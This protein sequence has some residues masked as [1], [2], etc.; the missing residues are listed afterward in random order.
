M[1]RGG[2]RIV[3]CDYRGHERDRQRDRD[4][5][6]GAEHDNVDS[7]GNG[8]DCRH[9]RDRYAG[10][11]AVFVRRVADVAVVCIERRHELGGGDLDER[12]RL[13]RGDQRVVDLR[14]VGRERIGQR[15]SRLLGRG[16]HIDI[17][18][19]GN[20]N[21]CRYDRDGYAGGGRVLVQ[22][23]AD[24]S[25]RDI[26]RRDEFCHGHDNERLQLD[27]G[28]QRV[29]AQRHHWR[30]RIRQ[31]D[32][33][34]LSGREY[35]DIEPDRNAHDCRYDRDCYAGGGRMRV[36]RVAHVAERRGWRRQRD[37]RCDDDVRVCLDG[38]EQRVLDHDSERRVRNRQW[39]RRARG[40]RELPEQRPNGQ[41]HD[42]RHDGD[43][44]GS[45]AERAGAAE[46]Y[47]FPRR[48]LVTSA[49]KCRRQIPMLRDG[50]DP[51][52]ETHHAANTRGGR[53]R[54]SKPALARDHAR[55]ARE[56]R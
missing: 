38:D 43:R 15:H 53:W 54:Q 41:R 28:E 11:G 29:V 48:K 55:G 52:H 34:V 44:D 8:D 7:H 13:D 18:P 51:D 24:I 3:D 31:W 47:S 5:F 32:G 4:L 6:S 2:E 36:H 20:A 10:G 40:C 21:D 56:R 39:I 30:E 23:L 37:G 19:Y 50:D 17:E 1:D 49:G 9:R 14:D 42:R 25:E 26:E 46:E 16:E 33:H 12:M 22:R 27:R 35:I 45:G